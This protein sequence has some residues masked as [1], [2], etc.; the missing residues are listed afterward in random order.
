MSVYNGQT[1]SVRGIGSKAAKKW[2]RFSSRSCIFR[3]FLARFGGGRRMSTVAS[4]RYIQNRFTRGTCLPR[5]GPL[6]AESSRSSGS[7]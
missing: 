6:L 4:S 3:W 1:G 2:R 7:H 5:E